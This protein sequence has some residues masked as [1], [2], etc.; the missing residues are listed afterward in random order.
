[1]TR[2]SLRP[3]STE[4]SSVVASSCSTDLR[5]A[6]STS[7]LTNPPRPRHHI[8]RPEFPELTGQNFRNLHPATVRAR[9]TVLIAVPEGIEVLS[10]RNTDGSWPRAERLARVVNDAYAHPTRRER[11]ERLVHDMIGRAADVLQS[12]HHRRV[13][14]MHLTPILAPRLRALDAALRP[15]DG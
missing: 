5:C 9:A 6:P 13:V 10:L 1:M 15:L 7:A 11:L 12:R 4:S 2:I 3:S 8:N 14:A